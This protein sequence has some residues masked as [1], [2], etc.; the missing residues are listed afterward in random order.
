MAH[1]WKSLCKPLF[2]IGDFLKLKNKNKNKTKQNETKRLRSNIHTT[3]ENRPRNSPTLD[4]NEGFL[5]AFRHTLASQYALNF[6]N[7]NF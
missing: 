4:H 3:Y 2:N 7:L 1:L 6:G 5:S